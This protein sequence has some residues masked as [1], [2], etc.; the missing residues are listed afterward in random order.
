MK[1]RRSS[2]HWFSTTAGEKLFADKVVRAPITTGL[3]LQ[4]ANDN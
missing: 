3:S 4:E 2:P 1:D